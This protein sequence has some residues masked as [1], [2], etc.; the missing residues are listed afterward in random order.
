MLEL[1]GISR[2]YQTGT[3]VQHALDNVSLAL[4][5]SEFVCI[6]GPSGSGKTTLLNIIGGLDRYDSGDLLIGGVST[7][8][9]RDRDW[10]TY[11][12]HTIGFV[13][14]SYN[15]IPHQTILA[16]IELSMTI[17][18]VSRSE[19]KR[20][21]MEA[22]AA[23]G[24]EG[25][26]HKRPNQ[27]SGGQMQRV[28]IARALV[29]DP[30][31]LL[32][33]EPTGALDSETSTQ[34]MELLSQVA[35]D[36]LVVMVTH[37]AEL[38][39]AYA[40][41][42]VNLKDG[43]IVGDSDPYQPSGN[44]P[45]KQRENQR[46]AKMSFRTALNLSF[47][48][49]RT[50]KGRTTLTAFAGSIGII[51]IALILAMSSSVNRY[52][53]DIQRETMSS[54]PITITAQTVDLTSLMQNQ[55]GY[56]A[57][58]SQESDGTPT[59]IDPDYTGLEVRSALTSSLLENNLAAFKRY[60]D[61]PDC[62]LLKYVGENGIRYSYNVSFEVYTLDSDGKIVNTSA[63]PSE[64]M[65][66]DS[67]FSFSSGSYMSYA[68]FFGSRNSS[69]AEN[70]SEL[71]AGSDGE[72][73]SQAIRDSYDLAWGRWPERADELILVLNINNALSVRS[74]YQ[75]GLITGDQYVEAVEAYSRGEMYT[76]PSIDFEALSD[77]RFVCVPAYLYYEARDDG[78]F[79]AVGGSDE[80]LARLM[81]NGIELRIVGVV[82]SND[83]MLSTAITTR[84][85]YTT[86]L[87][88]LLID[89]GNES[90]AVQAQL[91]SPEVSVI[92]GIP[93]AALSED[94]KVEAAKAYALSHKDE[95]KE[96]YMEMYGSMAG[97]MAGQSMLSDSM[98]EYYI[99]QMSN[100]QL[101]QMYNLL[102]EG[103]SLSENLTALGYVDRGSPSSISI[104]ADSFEA[105][106]AIG[107]AIRQY[108]ETAPED[109]RITYTDYIALITSS[110][111]TIVDVISY[112]LIAFVAV[113]LVV[114]CIMIGIITHISVLERTK[115]IGI[116]R[117]LGASK[118]N[119]S[120]VFNAETVI[121]G[122]FA[123][124][125]GVGIAWALTVPVNA[126]LHALTHVSTLNVIQQPLHAVI[127]VAISVI[128]TVIGGLIPARKAAAKDPVIALRTE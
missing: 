93:F 70:F 17:S 20:R 43:R 109:E 111:T 44:Q 60:L 3:L 36:R 71:M 11:R 31:I 125:M 96:M 128:I 58:A 104:Y 126:I 26:E 66:D 78:T 46:R 127:L 12:N 120:Q 113:S 2:H 48:N 107:E 5:D 102:V 85:G 69:G 59:A 97:G 14:Q 82:Q 34:V 98:L 92:T 29:N 65:E 72:A 79:M 88:N 73:V 118:R 56:Y 80:A 22:L 10:D 112:V 24:L 35:K 94:E 67:A 81:E 84:I 38:A 30:D 77:H 42:I 99:N 37:N 95:L 40:T 54:Y 106:D 55:D 90:D 1:R 23:V 19:R 89:L 86:M 61:D 117:A 45:M 7:R 52:I 15:L 103:E 33:D 9:Y 41:R 68:S 119:I 115:E 63:D 76:L 105:K 28:A 100:D 64:L 74:L 114:S 6:L 75:L 57:M 25:Q 51:G 4:R 91:A 53:A 62:E 110:I 39:E 124:L 87:T 18:G 121:I 16:N 116:L 101:L 8:D 32:A 13:F 49:L 47:Q 108:N 27:M 123:G 21:A 83:S 50:K 122:L